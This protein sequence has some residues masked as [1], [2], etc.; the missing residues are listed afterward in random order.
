MAFQVEEAPRQAGRGD[1]QEGC[2][3]GQR[4]QNWSPGRW[5]THR[6]GQQPGASDRELESELCG[7]TDR[8]RAAFSFSFILT[9]SFRVFLRV[10]CL[11]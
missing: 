1:L 9:S 8:S 6:E 11:E 7:Q 3:T 4:D 2:R 10:M 5:E